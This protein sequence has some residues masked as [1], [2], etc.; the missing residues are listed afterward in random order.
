MKGAD[1]MVECPLC[2]EFVSNLYI[3]QHIDSGCKEVHFA[4]LASNVRSKGNDDAAKA[5]G[6]MFSMNKPK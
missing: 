2:Q 4:P 5:W 6:K 3:N 1:T